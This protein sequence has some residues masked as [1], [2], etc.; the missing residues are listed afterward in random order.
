MASLPAPLQQIDRTWVVCQ[1][2]RFSFFG[3]CDYFRLSSDRRVI[4][5]LGRA[6]RRYGISTS[7]SRLTSGNHEL[8]EEVE[9]A[10]A[11][12]FGFPAAT[13]VSNGY[14]ANL[15]AAQAL[16][17]EFQS[18]W[19]DERSHSSVQLAAELLTAGRV[20]EH[21][22]RYRD[23]THLR[24][25]AQSPRAAAQSPGVGAL[26]TDG[27]FAHSGAVAPL[28]DYRPLLRAGDWLWIDDAHG[29]G[30]L[31]KHGRGVLD[32]IQWPVSRTLL[33]TTFSKAFG[34]Y[35]GVIL[36]SASVRRRILAGS[37]FFA[38]NTPPPLPV[39]AAALES[40]KVLTAEGDVLRDRL[41]RNTALVRGFVRDAG[42]P[43]WDTPGPILGVTTVTPRAATRLEQS[44]RKAGI[45]AP[46]ICY[47]GAPSEGYFRIV[48]SSEHTESQ[49]NSLGSTLAA[50]ASD[51][52]CLL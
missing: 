47:P 34:A 14:A 51:L 4:D 20:D 12:Y 49:L 21:R 30:T 42:A 23:A 3:G 1:G 8:Y 45:L 36:S 17:G 18:L 40:M 7:A 29:A 22:F 16:V 39:V 41:R 44:M 33:V 31:G 52:V 35:G 25:L 26:L 48:I 5:A 50:H 9:Q 38:G 24:E 43:M 15:I 11:R 13:L 2:R 28:S 27:L 32:G 10:A 46:R 19:M 6:T 37:H